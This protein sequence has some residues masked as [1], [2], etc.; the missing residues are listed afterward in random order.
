[1]FQ[2]LLQYT[3]YLFSLVIVLFIP[4]YFLISAINAKTKLFTT[5]EKFVL[6]LGVSIIV[7]DFMLLALGAFKLPITRGSIILATIIFS[8]ICWAISFYRKKDSDS[9][10]QE[11][12]IL[13]KKQLAA[14]VLILML[15]FFIRSIY[16]SGAIAPSATDLGHHMYW[17]NMIT[18]NGSIPNFQQQDI[19][20]S[21]GTYSITPPHNISD[22]IIGEHLIFAAISL[23]SGISVVSYF[24]VVTLLLINIFSLLAVFILVLRLFDSNHEKATNIGIIALLFLG[25]I[26]AISPPQAK[27]IGGGVI[28]NLI[29]NILVPLA[30]YFYCRTFKEKN[31]TML[32]LAILF[33]MALFYTHHLTALIF[34]LTLALIIFSLII[35]NA[36]NLKRFFKEIS[37]AV[38]SIPTI[39]T[40]IFAAI[41]VI[42]I[43]IPTYITNK[44]VS[45]VVGGPSKT[46]HG[47]LSFTAFKDTLGEPRLSL[48]IAGIILFALFYFIPKIYTIYKNKKDA[49]RI[50][51][52]LP[53]IFLLSWTLSISIISLFP[54]LIRIDIPSGRVANYGTYPFA[55]MGAY[56][57]VTLATFLRD[58]PKKFPLKK[59]FIFA[60]FFLFFAY[61]MSLG[62]FDNNQN[63]ST[64][65]TPQR[66]QETFHASQ[67][68]QKNIGDKDQLLSDHIN[69]AADSWVKIFFMK[70]YHFPLYRANLDRYDN[71]IDRQEK[72]TLNMI[73]SPSSEDSKKC[74]LDLGITYIMVN[75]KTDSAQFQKDNSFSLVYSN[76][77]VNIY[78]RKVQTK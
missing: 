70:D 31:P 18:K 17:S 3:A 39:G 15:S 77:D 72:C 21:N 45:T 2:L 48:A 60:V 42:G 22:F 40:L 54:T 32:S 25:P 35:T 7:T 9:E 8:A 24:P 52:L 16:L 30:L 29:G 66:V 14:I 19:A 75:K 76:D 64:L 38:I 65:A 62:Y 49:I 43:Y 23:I 4:G 26:F 12:E 63:T 68:L 59:S 33:S 71:G 78:H 67:Y 46:G 6:S 61:S 74:Y 20:I 36:L 27:F 56:A 37:A 34:L 41:F 50:D 5:L 51:E 58:N 28:G 55:I 44:A 73:S 11:K 1:M 69:L 57:I 10:D 13:S 47:G 53:S